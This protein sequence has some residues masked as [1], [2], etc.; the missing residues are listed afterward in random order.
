[1]IEQSGSVTEAGRWAVTAR[2]RLRPASTPTRL[3]P[4]V[5]FLGESGP[6]V[7]VAWEALI[8]LTPGCLA[9][10]G[11][12]RLP[13]GIREVRFTGVTDPRSHPVPAAASCIA[14]EVK[15]FLPIQENQS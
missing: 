8:P 1:M 9:E 4:V 7:A 5:V 13:A 10:G 11:G 15:K 12:M 3:I 14:V 2:I 6:G